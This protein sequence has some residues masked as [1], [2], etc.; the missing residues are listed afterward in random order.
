MET[1]AKS[2]SKIKFNRHYV[3]D[4]THKIKVR[5][6]P[7]GCG[8]QKDICLYAKEYGSQLSKI[9]DG[10]HNDSDVMTDYFTHD[11]LYLK[12]GSEHYE[13]AKAAMENAQDKRTAERIARTT[14]K[15]PTEP[16]RYVRIGKT[17]YAIVS[18]E[19]TD[20]GTVWTIKQAN[21]EKTL[22]YYR[23]YEYYGMISGWKRIPKYISMGN[24]SF[25]EVK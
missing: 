14:P 6:M 13:A 1:K 8:E 15:Q 10:V 7:S 19:A 23:K 5:Y 4:G 3:T 11:S 2:E 20:Y 25:F 16:G 17:C 21:T 22:A 9:F 12:P 18:T 24:I